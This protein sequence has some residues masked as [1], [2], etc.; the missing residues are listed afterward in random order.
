MLLRRAIFFLLILLPGC[1][2]W[3][4]TPDLTAALAAAR[5]HAAA[6]RS[7]QAATVF[8]RVIDLAAAAHSSTALCEARN[9]LASLSVRNGDYPGAI[10]LAGRSLADCPP[11]S[12]GHRR[13][14][15]TLGQ[16]QLYAGAYEPAA[17]SFSNVRS[18]AHAAGDSQAEAYAWNNLGGAQYYRGLYYDAHR[19][20]LSAERLVNSS[21]AA[22]WTT[23]PRRITLA[24]Q[25][26]LNQRL[27]RDLDALK[28]YRSLRLASAALRPEEEAQLLANLGALYRRLGDPPK[29][30]SLYQSA[31]QLLSRHANPDT[32]LSLTKNAGIVQLLDLDDTAAAE[33]TFRHTA[34]L[35]LRTGSPREQMQAHLYLGETMLRQSR[36]PEAVREFSLA[37]QRSRELKTGEERWKALHGLARVAIAQGRLPHALS[38][39]QEAARLVES[40]RASLHASS[41]RSDFMADKRRLYDDAISL[42]LRLGVSSVHQANQLL[43]WLERSRSRLLQD[44]F[45]PRNLTLPALQQQLDDESLLLLYWRG[46][47][48]AA[49]LW[50][51]RSA[52]GVQPLSS[53]T[54][55]DSQFDLRLR[56]LA[57]PAVDSAPWRRKLAAELLP[58]ASPLH[59]PRF[60][61][62]IIVPDGNI[63]AIPFDSLPLSD[64]RLLLQHAAVTSLP[65]AAL[66]LAPPPPPGRRFPWQPQLLALA[67]PSAPPSSALL[68]GD[69]SWAPLP[70]A[71]AEARAV[72]A[73]LPGSATVLTGAAAESSLLRRRAAEFPVL[74]LATHAVSDAE[75]PARSRLLLAGGPDRGWA[76]LFHSDVASLS[77]PRTELVTLSACETGH[78]RLLRGEGP[79]S[80]ANAFLLAGASATVSTL[81]RVEDAAA[82]SL[83][84]D[85]YANLSAG[86]TK[87][88]SL[89][90]A[91]L[92]FLQRHPAR[93]HPAFWSAFVLSGDGWRPLRPVLA[94]H[95][96]A[97]AFAAFLLLLA[98]LARFVNSSS[99]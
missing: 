74:H 13:A 2:L 67:N 86:M 98:A 90:A 57:D 47:S 95:W 7:A 41:L 4:D 23:G 37:E 84:R 72:A 46:G 26:M 21:P 99:R 6:G 35:A 61:H 16:A 52:W 71:Q 88:A 62:W 91:K 69:S 38:L 30:L 55:D 64:G 44:R 42:L 92:R 11:A 56:E 17:Q 87:A 12:P 1:L 96:L 83:M 43:L 9:A 36:L 53:T 79:Q 65:S 76:Y 3:P 40:A 68:A 20:F 5:Q 70:N 29:A 75:D 77:L 97:A 73:V 28:I 19:S 25:A 22:P 63:A 33:R 81:W 94:W 85:F 78:G 39:L 51:S 80:L 24:N 45:P 49:L 15:N 18:L 59:D 93:R 31:R 8:R 10:D 27:G 54:L 58:A 32:L 89:R 50:L 48:S 82:A 66:L 60:R 34:S 14:W